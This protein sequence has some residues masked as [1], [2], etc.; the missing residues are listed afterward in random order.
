MHPNVIRQLLGQ[1]FTD[2]IL[3]LDHEHT[4]SVLKYIDIVLICKFNKQ[5]GN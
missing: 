5:L 4:Q 2:E 1:M 3:L